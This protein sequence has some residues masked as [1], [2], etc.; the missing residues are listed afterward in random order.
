M[1]TWAEVSLD[2]LAHNYHA[3]RGLTPYGTKFMGLVKAD[4]YGHGAVPIAQ[5]LEELGADYLGVACLA[6]AV[7]LRQAGVQ[8]PILILGGT[9]AAYAAELVRYHITQACYD[10][11][12]A[13]ALSAQVQETGGT[14]TVHIQC[15]TGMSRLGFLCHEDTMEQ[16]AQ[17][18]A[19]AVE[20]ER[21]RRDA[22]YKGTRY[23]KEAVTTV[24]PTRFAMKRTA[25]KC[26][27]P[28]KQAEYAYSQIKAAK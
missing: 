1:R 18:I 6:E 4:A 10:L 26:Q 16:A 14:L 11:D 3:L 8:T 15:D 28:I 22:L 24:I 27:D 17:E 21:L 2:R 13:K 7:E 5:K 12:Y 19:Q 23:T 20:A 25:P 9:P